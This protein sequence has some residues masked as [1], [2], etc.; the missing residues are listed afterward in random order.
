[1]FEVEVLARHTRLLAGYLNHRILPRLRTDSLL[2]KHVSLMILS[3]LHVVQSISSPN[4]VDGQIKRPWDSIGKPDP[5][6]PNLL[7]QHLTLRLHHGPV[8][9]PDK[10][11]PPDEHRFPFARPLRKEAVLVDI[12]V[13]HGL[14]LYVHE[15][16]SAIGFHPQRE[17]SIGI[18][19]PETFPEDR[20]RAVAISPCRIACSLHLWLVARKLNGNAS[21]E[22]CVDNF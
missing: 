12:G 14:G 11:V 1:M 6:G 9:R 13:Y 20:R 5:Y 16:A 4:L 22:S 17:K 10:F 3:L 7:L 19:I 18:H 21:V 8:I 2:W 15:I